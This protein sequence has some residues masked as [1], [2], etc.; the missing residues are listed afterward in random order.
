MAWIDEEDASVTFN[1]CARAAIQADCRRVAA[2]REDEGFQ[3]LLL[4]DHAANPLHELRANPTPTELRRDLHFVDEQL[5]RITVE[6]LKSIRNEETSQVIPNVRNDHV[7]ADIR[8]EPLG[9]RHGK[10]GRLEK[11]GGF[12]R[13]GL[14]SSHQT[15]D[16][17][18][19]SMPPPEG[20]CWLTDRV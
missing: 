17:H 11:R 7:V 6:P 8:K 9:P 10:H 19:H 13:S 20:P 18:V 1:V 3:E 15:T 12:G 14:V 5:V 2:L 16:R 4:I